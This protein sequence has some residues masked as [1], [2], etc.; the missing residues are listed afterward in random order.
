MDGLQKGCIATPASPAWKMEHLM[1]NPYHLRPAMASDVPALRA[2]HRAALSGLAGE[3]YSA[4]QIAGFFADVE[5]VDPNL[6]AD[7]TYWLIE[8][9]GSP[10]A[11]GGWT[12]RAPSYASADPD[13]PGDATATVRAVFTDPAHARRGLARRIMEHIERD[14]VFLGYAE[15][16]NLH[17]TLS[18]LPL[19]LVLGYRPIRSHTLRLSN[20]LG[21]PAIAM[22]KTSWPLAESEAVVIPAFRA[23]AASATVR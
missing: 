22:S 18:G 10:V 3:H 7:G 15:R 23:P 8:H 12:M 13:A 19:Y 20:G 17:A 21:F 5:T 11:S 2:L 14:A 4:D 6:I 16:I 9:E 1:S